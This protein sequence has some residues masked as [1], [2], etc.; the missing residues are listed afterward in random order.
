MTLD[1]EKEYEVEIHTLYRHIV[2]DYICTNLIMQRKG[3][4]V[5]LKED[6]EFD[7]VTY[8]LPSGQQDFD[9]WLKD[10]FQIK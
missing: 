1:R 10:K 3:N 6:N 4:E 5:I 7:G 2:K 9:K 8:T